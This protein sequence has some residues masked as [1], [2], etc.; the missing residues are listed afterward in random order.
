MNTPQDSETLA[1][2]RKAR[3][4]FVATIS[5]QDKA[6]FLKC[7]NAEQLLASLQAPKAWSNKPKRWKKAMA[8][9]QAFGEC[10]TPYFEIISI[11]LQS[12]PEWSMIVWG[13]VRLMLKVYIPR[14]SSCRIAIDA[15]AAHIELFIFLRAID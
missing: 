7:E 10:L 5:T 1:Q 8:H 11:V 14:Y 3:D 9:V 2:F 12:N 4:A 15:N 6:Q 13:A